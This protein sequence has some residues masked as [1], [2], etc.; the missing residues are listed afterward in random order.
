MKDL[1]NFLK[2]KL[3][4]HGPLSDKEASA[5]DSVYNDLEDM[6]D[7][8]TGKGMQAV[9]VMAKDKPSLEAGLDKAK[10]IVGHGPSM[11]DEGSDEEES[12]ESDAESKL[13]EAAAEMTSEEIE[14]AIQMLQEMKAK[15]ASPSKY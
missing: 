13:E 10:E 9:K 1:M 8:E 12:Q 3:D 5:R 11:A 2:N 14:H 15:K 6:A 7:G 4:K